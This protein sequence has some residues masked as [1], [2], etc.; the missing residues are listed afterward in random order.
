M[1]E[2]RRFR[3]TLPGRGI[4]DAP[5]VVAEQNAREYTAARSVVVWQVLSTSNRA[6]LPGRLDIRKAGRPNIYVMFENRK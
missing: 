5:P 4:L 1:Q 3:S 6:V 2:A